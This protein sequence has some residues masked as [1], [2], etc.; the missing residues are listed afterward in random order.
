[1]NFAIASVTSLIGNVIVIVVVVVFQSV[2]HL[3]IYQNNV[4]F[5]F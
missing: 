3:E 5:I 4:F 1:M 2:C